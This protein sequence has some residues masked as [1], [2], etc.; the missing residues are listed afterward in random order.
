MV[1]SGPELE[2]HQIVGL[3]QLLTIHDV[4]IAVRVTFGDV[5]KDRRHALISSTVAWFGTISGE[6]AS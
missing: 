2:A 6:R 1:G 3:K 4:L 5:Q